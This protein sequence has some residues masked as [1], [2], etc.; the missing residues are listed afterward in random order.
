MVLT[1]VL[2]HFMTVQIFNNTIF[3]KINK[4]LFVLVTNDNQFHNTEG[5]STRHKTIHI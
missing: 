5:V 1:A 2:T 4:Y 3:N